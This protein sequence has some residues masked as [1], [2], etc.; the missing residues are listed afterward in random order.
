MEVFNIFIDQAIGNSKGNIN[1]QY[2]LDQIKQAEK[3][4]ATEL[5]LIINSPGGEVYE[6]YSIYN[7][8]VESDFKISA[9]V[10]GLCASIATL[11]ASAADKIEMSETAQ[12]MIHEAKGG[13]EGKAEDLESTARGM[14]QIN[15]MIAKNYSRKTGKSIDEIKEAMTFDNYMTPQQAKEFG[16]IDNIRMPIAAWGEYK[17]NLIADSKNK[18]MNVVTQ[19]MKDAFKA[20]EDVVKSAIKNNDQLTLENFQEPLADGETILYGEGELAAGKAVFINPEM[21]DKASAGEHALANGK[22]IVVDEAGIIVEVR[23][24]EANAGEQLAEA[25]VSIETLKAEKLTLE[26]EV[27]TLKANHTKELENVGKQLTTLKGQIFSDGKAPKPANQ[28]SAKKDMP[29]STL[30]IQAQQMRQKFGIK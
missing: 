29:A 2:I 22:L 21:T 20:L 13:A 6:G 11:I 28:V 4:G 27:A 14:R 10:T 7:T 5:K 30:D 17:P 3:A 9:F 18:N 26:T 1:N 12:W 25:L 24:V 8:L 15:D 23:E 16:F 19:K